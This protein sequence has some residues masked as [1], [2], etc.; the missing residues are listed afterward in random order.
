[1]LK[2]KAVVIQ[3]IAQ[4]E[5]K[6]FLLEEAALYGLLALR[7]QLRFLKNIEKIFNSHNMRK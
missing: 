6:T 2:K 7:E 3:K 5:I 1:M 4:A